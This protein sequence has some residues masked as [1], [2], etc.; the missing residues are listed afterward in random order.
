M[1]DEDEA[2]VVE[3][4]TQ[5]PQSEE[6]EEHPAVAHANK[7]AAEARKLSQMVAS[8]AAPAAQGSTTALAKKL[9]IEKN[10]ST[11]CAGI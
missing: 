10:R 6:E 8:G 5:D 3:E 2:K 1:S 11:Y 4:E 7:V 9:F